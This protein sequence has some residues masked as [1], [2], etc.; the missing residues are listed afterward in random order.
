M[1]NKPIKKYLYDPGVSNLF[2]HKYCIQKYFFS[3]SIYNKLNMIRRR[4]I[5]GKIY[6]K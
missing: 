4:I 1:H 3:K 6:Q 2:F 5:K